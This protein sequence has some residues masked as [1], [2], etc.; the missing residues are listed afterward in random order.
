MCS[1]GDQVGLQMLQFQGDA[2]YPS[3][4]ILTHFYYSGIIYVHGLG[5]I[6]QSKALSSWGLLWYTSKHREH[7]A[8]RKPQVLLPAGRRAGLLCSGAA[9]LQALWGFRSSP[10][11]G[12][13]I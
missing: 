4:S 11:L 3:A 9:L 10:G 12:W 6:S 8:G 1:N 13:G 7:K 2:H 5:R